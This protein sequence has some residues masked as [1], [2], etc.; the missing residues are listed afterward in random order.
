MA[1]QIIFQ[2]SRHQFTLGNEP[3]VRRHEPAA[4]LFQQGLMVAAE[5]DRIY[6]RV[7]V[8]KL[9]DIFPHELVRSF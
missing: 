8:K 4:F 2:A 6:L 1:V 3:D 9:V 7:F 5:Y